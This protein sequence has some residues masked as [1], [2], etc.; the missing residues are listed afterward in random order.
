MGP[1]TFRKSIFPEIWKSG[2]PRIRTFGCSEIG[3]P[4]IRKVRM[5]DFQMYDFLD[6]RQIGKIKESSETASDVEFADVGLPL[7]H[8][9]MRQCTIRSDYPLAVISSTATRDTDC[10]YGVGKAASS[11]EANGFLPSFCRRGSLGK[12]W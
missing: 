7:K 8:M 6:F 10:M 12:A 1:D 9:L 3:L 4:K 2:V 11:K 5:P